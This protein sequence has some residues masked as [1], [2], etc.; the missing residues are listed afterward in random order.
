MHISC[1][2]PGS[3]PWILPSLYYSGD[4]WSVNLTIRTRGSQNSADFIIQISDNQK[5]Y[6]R[7]G[8][9]PSRMVSRLLAHSDDRMGKSYFKQE[10]PSPYGKRFF[11]VPPR[12]ECRSVA[13]REGE[14]QMTAPHALSTVKPFEGKRYDEG[15]PQ[16]GSPRRRL[17]RGTFIQ[18]W[19]FS[20]TL[21]NRKKM[22]VASWK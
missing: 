9:I 12:H 11:R 19:N 15:G 10:G 8:A 13:T 18:T 5:I 22:T 7:T 6:E 1:G 21:R 3:G 20:G 2:N 17:N 16:N 14:K 4:P